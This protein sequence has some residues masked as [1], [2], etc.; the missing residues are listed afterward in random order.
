MRDELG[1]LVGLETSEN[2][3]A[4]YQPGDH[5]RVELAQFAPRLAVHSEGVVLKYEQPRF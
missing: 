3:G 5:V 2:R 1:L 4:D